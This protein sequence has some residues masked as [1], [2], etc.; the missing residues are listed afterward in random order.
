MLSEMREVPDVADAVRRLRLLRID[1]DLIPGKSSEAPQPASDRAPAAI[2]TIELPERGICIPGIR[3]WEGVIGFWSGYDLRSPVDL[4]LSDVKFIDPT[5]PL[6]ALATGDALPLPTGLSH[7]KAFAAIARAHGRPVGLGLHTKDSR[8][9]SEFASDGNRELRFMALLAAQE[10]GELAAILGEGS[11]LEGTT[12]EACWKWLDK[13]AFGRTTFL[14]ALPSALEQYRKHLG[15][16]S[17]LPHDY[18]ALRIWCARMESASNGTQP[19]RS[20]AKLTKEEDCGFPIVDSAGVRDV[21]S[22]RSLFADATME[23]WLLDFD[24]EHLPSGCFELKKDNHFN[25]LLEGS[26]KI[27]A[28]VYECGRLAREYETALEI[29]NFFPVPQLEPPTVNL[30][31]A[32]KAVGATSMETAIAIFLQDIRR[33]HLLFKSWE[34]L[35]KNYTWHPI[36]DTFHDALDLEGSTLQAWLERA[37]DLLVDE[38]ELRHNTIMDL[39]E[40]FGHGR[41]EEAPG[42]DGFA[43]EDS[44]SAREEDYGAASKIDLSYP[45]TRRL[46]GLLRSMGVVKRLKKAYVQDGAKYSKD[47]IPR[48]PLHPPIGFVRCSEFGDAFSVVSDELLDPS[49]TLRALFGYDRTKPDDIL[50]RTIGRAFGIETPQGTAFLD[51]FRKGDPPVG[52]VKT[53]CRDFARYERG[54]VDSTTWPEALR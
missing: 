2:E 11:E 37:H 47:R 50:Q 5:S 52:W 29:L 51:S 9:W 41:G 31:G 3:S 4:I 23:P 32:R 42:A 30:S 20:G 43:W 24:H 38:G 28:L 44:E 35:F 12:A 16:I 22:L 10:A 49:V 26:P 8:I 18:D 33:E 25:I 21:I 40:N 14:D 36:T 15:G 19:E 6:S 7:F 45:G 13:R 53:L 48:Q 46:I 54:W 17:L 39:F 1:D 27:G 34:N